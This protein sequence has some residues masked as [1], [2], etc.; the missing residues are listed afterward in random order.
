MDRVELDGGVSDLREVTDALGYLGKQVPGNYRF[1]GLSLESP[2]LAKAAMAFLF[3][4]LQQLG[5]DLRL[6]WTVEVDITLI[7]VTKLR[8][9]GCPEIDT[10][11][12]KSVSSLAAGDGARIFE[13]Y[14]L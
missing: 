6:P 9:S 11:G 1:A 12:P 4:E 5:Q 3:R 7:F 2:G 13:T 8:N 14:R 10:T